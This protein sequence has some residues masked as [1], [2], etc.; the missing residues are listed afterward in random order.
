MKL[1]SSDN[2]TKVFSTEELEGKILAFEQAYKQ[3]LENSK[4]PPYFSDAIL[5][6]FNDAHQLFEEII[7]EI[8]P[9]S[10][11][12]FYY[13]YVLFLYNFGDYLKAFSFS[14]IALTYLNQDTQRIFYGNTYV[15]QSAILLVQGNYNTCIEISEKAIAI[16]QALNDPTLLYPPT[17]NLASSYY[18]TGKYEKALTYYY[19][20]LERHK[21]H[22]LGVSYPVIYYNYINCLT[23]QK[24]YD[25][26][27]QECRFLKQEIEKREYPYGFIWVYFAYCNYYN[28]TSNANQL[29]KYTQKAE[30]IAIEL[31]LFKHIHTVYEYY[32]DAYILKG[33]FE[34]AIE[35]AIKEF[36]KSQELKATDIELR[37]LT[38]IIHIYLKKQKIALSYLAHPALQQFEQSITKIAQRA[39]SIVSNKGLPYNKLYICDTLIKLYKQEG[40]IEK[41][42]HF[43]ELE[44]QL[45]KK[46]YDIEKND[47]VF[48]LQ[49]EYENERLAQELIYQKD[50]LEQQES[51]NNSLKNFAYSASHDMKEPLR[52]ITSF[53]QLLKRKVDTQQTDQLEYIEYIISASSRMTSLLDDLLQYSL[54]GHNLPDLEQVDI[55]EIIFIVRSNLQ[56]AILKHKATITHTPLPTISG[57]QV[58][59]IQLFQNIISN[60]LKF[61]MLDTPPKI[62]IHYEQKDQ[63]H[64]FIISDNGIGIP[65][66]KQ[67]LIF[68]TFSRLHSKTEFPGSGIGLASCKKVIDIYGGN[69]WAESKEGKGSQFHITIPIKNND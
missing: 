30:S 56:H 6:E 52:M 40:E 24:R 17:N 7:E 16:L 55:E 10:A 4:H 69:I 32:T 49:K 33:E 47:L 25:I 50:L 57:H 5:Q 48:R 62:H 15:I 58:L 39:E 21:T 19:Q 27:E 45:L 59:F 12:A 29:L 53:G 54:M 37:S 36:E 26:I 43:L 8:D 64:Y 61:K 41:A 28:K 65:I 3:A 66:E 31:N 13:H 1:K 23:Y 42:I 68:E 9:L 35:Y 18:E 44:N 60:G 63:N 67:Q 11:G 22:D 38:N 2:I 34:K 46:V 14:E 20:L 51:I